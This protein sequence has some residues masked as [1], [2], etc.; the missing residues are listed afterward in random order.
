MYSREETVSINGKDVKF[1]VKDLGYNWGD[2]VRNGVVV[3]L[4]NTSSERFC[5]TSDGENG[6]IALYFENEQSKASA[7][8]AESYLAALFPGM[9]QEYW[10]PSYPYPSEP[11]LRE[12]GIGPSKDG[13]SLYLSSW[14]R[15]FEDEGFK[16]K[17]DHIWRYWSA[18]NI[19]AEN[20]ILFQFSNNRGNG[21]PKIYKTPYGKLIIRVADGDLDSKIPTKEFFDK[22]DS[23]IE[24]LK[25]GEQ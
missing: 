20:N 12:A 1:E 2:P 6:M 4:K 22:L 24:D 23:V 21:E 8:A 25:K 17:W 10:I 18:Y 19:C 7:K 13:K 11:V 14:F 5:R 16:E 3:E 15:S 9:E